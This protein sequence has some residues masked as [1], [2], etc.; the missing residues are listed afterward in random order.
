MHDDSAFYVAA[1]LYDDDT[2]ALVAGVTERDG[3][4]FRDDSFEIFIDAIGTGET[5]VH[6]V[7]NSIGTQLDEM[8][9]SR[10]DDF[11]WAKGVSVAD[12]AW[13][14]ELALPF[15]AGEAPA[16]G[17]TWHVGA[18][19]NMP[20][21]GEAS[22]WNG[23]ENGFHESERFGLLTFGGPNIS[24]KVADMGE[25]RLGLNE[26]HL[27]ADNATPQVLDYKA[28]IRVH[29]RDRSGHYFSSVKFPAPGGSRT[30]VDI[31]YQVT[32]D[33]VGSVLISVT[34][35]TGKPVFRTA[36]LP[37]RSPAIARALF[38]AEAALASASREW[39]KL[40]ASDGK[41]A[42]S[43]GI[44]TL[45]TRWRT[46]S[47]LAVRRGEMTRPEQE[48]MA[49]AAR[50]LAGDAGRLLQR[51]KAVGVTGRIALPFA[52]ATTTPL[53]KV[54]Q[55]DVA[56]AAYE[57]VQLHACRNE[58]EAFQI[59]IV[60][61]ESAPQVISVEASSLAGEAGEIDAEQIIIRPIGYVPAAD[62]LV[63][64]S[65]KRPYPDMLADPL[66]SGMGIQVEP[67][68]TS[69]LWVT[70]KVPADAQ[71]GDY[72]G[73]IQATSDEASLEVPVALTVHPIS[74]PN[75]TD[76]RATIGFWQSPHRIAEQ[77]GLELWS[78]DHWALIRTYLQDMADHGQDLAFATRDLVEWRR[79]EA[80][81]P[82]FNYTL[83]DRY[84][85][86]CREVGIDEGIE[87]Y[88]M[89]N[90][91]G[92]SAITWVGPDGD[93]EI[94]SASPGDEP[95]DSAWTAFLT[96]FASHLEE[97]GW[98]DDVYICPADEP[99]DRPDVPTLDRF[100]RC[101]ELVHAAHPKLGTTVALDSLEVGK[102]LADSIDRMVFK[103]RDDVY[104]RELAEAKVL[105]GGIVEAYICCHPDRPN[106]FI[107]SPN[108][109][110]RVIGWLMFR[111]GLQGL[112]RWSYE[113]WPVDPSGVP[114][115]DGKYAAGDLF[116]VYPGPDGPYS[117]PRWEILR[118][119]IED[120]ELLSILKDRIDA[121]RAD[122]REAQADAAEQ[123]L[124]RALA[125]VA[126]DGPELIGYT[127]D[128][129]TLEQA[130][131]QIIEALNGLASG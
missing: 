48:E 83:F 75:P 70:V 45:A 19:R 87:Y 7:I 115:G 31:P 131:V 74:L 18:A 38:D 77:Y 90:A 89:F 65:E 100:K 113:R 25:R 82:V 9:Q 15:G 59:V 44:G 129:A 11:Q 88:S 2:D 58:T 118:D 109:D 84:I 114:E 128:P 14:I 98:L 94:I 66:G 99:R 40:E 21:L 122:G 120:H 56:V 16:P 121:A 61:F 96:D 125:A 46:L 24:F 62:H 26:A 103:L 6:L 101:A 17:T 69:A 50:R 12:G 85:E 57:T 92:D 127:E 36:A 10:V 104:D 5:Y 52:L 41:T 106:T 117:T 112:L 86:V 76:Y 116:I 111:E 71:P 33:G 126:G 20:R 64:A 81:E 47:D 8:N 39:A 28:N 78:R 63:T 37:I 35:S 32:Q 91:S 80:G 60:P 13:A 110:S 124:S 68:V 49:V 34:D 107:T 4:V 53:A 119:G 42:L 102:A 79:D 30:P 108:I 130:R 123:A 43:G 73:T 23:F 105:D 3:D 55:D 97:N 95:Y 51:I 93:T 54:F 1:V 67:G 22:S 29:G 27:F 72:E